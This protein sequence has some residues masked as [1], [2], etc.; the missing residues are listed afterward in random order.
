MADDK[1]GGLPADK[2]QFGQNNASE[3]H[4][5]LPSPPGRSPDPDPAAAPGTNQGP[6]QEHSGERS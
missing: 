6:H 1:A 3:E 5:P 2:G 4:K